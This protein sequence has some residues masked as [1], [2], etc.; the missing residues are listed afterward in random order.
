MG[1]K[2][3]GMLEMFHVSNCVCRCSGS[4]GSIVSLV[5]IWCVKS[6]KEIDRLVSNFTPFEM[7]LFLAKSVVSRK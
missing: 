3:E 4:N 1:S 7:L 6:R 2:L 5:T